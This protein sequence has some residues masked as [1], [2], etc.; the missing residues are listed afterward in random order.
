MSVWALALTP[1]GTEIVS[2]DTGGGLR[3]W[4]RER[5]EPLGEPAA[6]HR[7][8]I[9]AVA[10]SPDGGE[11]VTGGSDGT[12]RRWDRR[13]GRPLA[14]PIDAGQDW[15]R[16]L[17]VTDS[18]ILS[19]G[20]DGTIHRWNRNTGERAGS[21][22]L[23]GPVWALG[24]ARD[25]AEVIA[26]GAA[27]ARWD[28]RRTPSF[29][30]PASIWSLAVTADGTEIV[31]GGADGVVR[32]WNRITGEPAGEISPGHPGGIRAL[33]VTADG[34]EI[35]TGG[36]DG[37]VR[38]WGSLTGRPAGDPLTCGGAVWT[39][40]LTPGDDEIVAGG[41]DG[42]IRRWSRGAGVLV[43]EPGDVPVPADYDADQRTDEALWRPRDRT[44][45]VRPSSGGPV[46]HHGVPA[47]PVPAGDR[48]WVTTLAS[49]LINAGVEAWNAG[50]HP[51][52][53]ADFDDALLAV[54][55]LAGTDL[56]AHGPTLI[57]W[58][59]DPIGWMLGADGRHERRA[60]LAEEA[61]STAR[62]LEQKRV[63]ALALL[64][65]GIAL[66]SIPARQGEAVDHFNE[67]LDVF[68]P[69]VNEDLATYGPTFVA[70]VHDP[71]GWMLGG[72]GRN[73]RR[74][75]LAEEA[76]AIARRLDELP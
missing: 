13:T 6:A 11:I 62:E 31:T 18:Q 9:W 76:V 66:Y 67:S 69:L 33:A 65:W 61:V 50:D 16:S 42:V 27:L 30:R 70:W 8:T 53:F 45:H 54:R 68:R 19:G 2:T 74:A 39:L 59:H 15:V 44:L 22:A 12:V 48:R 56:A 64:D 43:P 4:H 60:T 7:R 72:M 29:H 73:E 32:R 75:E 36:L 23:N 20:Q 5:E 17:A 37:T 10:I 49:A 63:L 52:A 71:I 25:G 1:D 38:R 3:R 46:W 51:R 24:A 35:V 21:L 26:G 14:D 57:A 40:A 28:G 55:P 41:R 58:I 34:A 47:A